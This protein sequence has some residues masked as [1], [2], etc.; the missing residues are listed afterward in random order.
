MTVTS[1][2]FEAIHRASDQTWEQSF[3]LVPHIVT[4]QISARII[5]MRIVWTGR[6][7]SNCPLATFPHNSVSTRYEFNASVSWWDRALVLSRTSVTATLFSPV[8]DPETLLK[9]DVICVFLLAKRSLTLT[10]RRGGRCTR[11]T[12]SLLGLSLGLH[13]MLSFVSE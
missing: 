4:G 13:L 3:R 1:S 9:R 8:A 11:H 6:H 7:T 2:D 12:L 5:T 10:E